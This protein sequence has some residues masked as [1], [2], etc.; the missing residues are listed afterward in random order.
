MLV[1][2]AGGILAV[3]KIL[4][5]SHEFILALSC[6]IVICLVAILFL[7]PRVRIYPLIIIF[8][9]IGAL[10]SQ[11]NRHPSRLI[12]LANLHKRAVIEGT[13]LDPP[14]IIDGK[15]AKIK[16]RAQELILKGDAV[17]IDEDIV[18][19]VY[20]HIPKLE[21]GD[22]IRFP[23]RLRAFKNFN[24]PGNYNYEEAMRLKGL[25]CS[26]SVSDGRRIVPMG[27][28]HLPFPRG[29]I[30]TIQKPVRDLFKEQLDARN[31][32][33]FRALILGERQGLDPALR[34]PFNQTGLGHML[35]VSGLHIGL[36]AW[37]AFFLFKWVLSRSYRLALEI[38]VR[39]MSAFLTAFPVI[40]YTLLAGFQVSSQR[41]MIMILAFLGSLI[42]GREREVWSTLALAG[43]IILFLDP[44]ALFSI[45]FQLSFMAVIGI[46]WLTPAILDKFH[47]LDNS[48]QVR[49]SFLNRLLAYFTG[50]VAVTA[51]ATIFLIP[52]TCYYFHRISLVSIPANLTT[53]PILGMWVIPLGLLSAITAPFSSNVACFFLH[54]G[55]WGLNKMMAIIEFWSHI[56][57]SSIWTVTP[58]LFET[59]LFYSFILGIFFFKRRRWAKIGVAL[60]ATLILSD[61]AY[62][63]YQVRFNRDLEVT[64]LDVGQ[65]NAALVAFPG[66]KK[67]IIDGGGFSRGSFDVGKMVVASY[68]WH[69]KI[70]QIDYVVL[71]H[72]QADHMNG[73]RFIAKAF[74]PKEFWYNGDQVETETFRDL[75]AIIEAG[76]IKTLLPSDLRNGIEI[77]G[78]RVNILHPDPDGQPLIL[79]KD[80]KWL[81]NNSLVLKIAYKGKTFLFP[82]DLEKPGE[83]VLV[84]NAGE[85][86]RSDIL[87]SPHHG[88]KTSSSKEFLGMVQPGICIISSREGSSNNFPHQTVLDRLRVM[89]CRVIRISR[90]GAVE[91]I[92]GKDRFKVRTFLEEK[93]L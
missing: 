5:L 84:S 78:V 54:L 6:S 9:L 36:V 11:G 1:S 53:V 85:M 72:P 23:A 12:P 89:G 35:A 47:Y 4:P 87:L 40:G 76:K 10:L 2:F 44:N 22:K 48:Q 70:S 65:G 74:R 75:M 45:S 31:F 90:S 33:L 62:W 71:S 68:L 64:F 83:E 79:E 34:E 86:I 37:V 42:L 66:G 67:M 49:M 93:G 61:V 7:S 19:T 16:L 32:A 20:N 21:A 80:G 41:A 28:G 13:V 38:D 30:E 92:V 73:L 24:N 56:P 39:K 77:N 82:G 27:P 29:L 46:L 55:A 60:I 25:T 58:N 18:V 26:A 88:S 57:W 63:V 14:K 3:H 59:F 43:L 51:S 91:V 8:F 17:P 52:I 81:N 15:I 69:K 50:L